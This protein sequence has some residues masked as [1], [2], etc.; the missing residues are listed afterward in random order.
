MASISDT[1]RRA[2]LMAWLVIAMSVIML[3][4]DNG[5]ALY[6]STFPVLTMRGELV[7]RTATEIQVRMVG[8]KDRECTYVNIQ[9][10][11]DTGDGALKDV[12][13]ARADRPQTSKTR[14]AGVYDIGTW[15]IWP[16]EGAKTVTVFVQ[17]SCDGRLVLSKVAEIVL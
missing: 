10:Y 2:V 17:H 8:T 11:V 14:P 4:K 15:R 1:L 9:A 3:F 7:S 16:T 13:I 5:L 12:F 6:D